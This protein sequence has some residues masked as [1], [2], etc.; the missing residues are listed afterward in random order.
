VILFGSRVRGD[1]EPDSDWDLMVVVDDDVPPEQCTVRAAFEAIAGTR[2]AAD[3]VPV[4]ASTFEDRCQVVN[5]LPWSA[6]TEGVVVYERG[7]RR[8]GA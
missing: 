2:I 8:Q 5:F 4:R 1:A 7:G 6:A 3:V